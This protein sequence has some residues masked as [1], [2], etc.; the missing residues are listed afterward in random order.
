MNYKKCFTGF[1]MAEVLITI[2]II[3]VVAAMTFPA[4]VMHHRNKALESQFKKYY[5]IFS[6]TAN[7]FYCAYYAIQDKCPDGSGKSYF[8]CLPN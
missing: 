5:S 1:T 6:Q 8:N 7:G 3:G 4:L 2:G